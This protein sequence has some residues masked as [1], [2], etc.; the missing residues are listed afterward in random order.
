MVIEPPTH[1]GIE[2]HPKGLIHGRTEVQRSDR[3]VLGVGA[4]ADPQAE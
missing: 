3:T 2:R 4:A 1:L